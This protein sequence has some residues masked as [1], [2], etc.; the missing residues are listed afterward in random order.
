M[1]NLCGNMA[2]L[3]ERRRKTKWSVEMYETSWIWAWPPLMHTMT[4]F[5]F[6][7]FT[8]SI[9]W[10]LYLTLTAPSPHYQ[11]NVDTRKP[12]S[13]ALR[14]WFVLRI[15]KPN[16]NET[17]YT[18]E[19][20]AH[21]EPLAFHFQRK[22]DHSFEYC[23]CAR[24][25]AFIYMYIDSLAACDFHFLFTAVDFSFSLFGVFFALSVSLQCSSLL[26]TFMR[27]A[28]WFSLVNRFICTLASTRA[29]PNVFVCVCLFVLR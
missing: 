26:L 27:I 5:F 22:F 18:T 16:E 28:K 14:M 15:P 29:C 11:P 24:A 21:I 2:K 8:G 4:M 7:F 25:C 17:S 12:I 9:A 1:E 6:W 10:I 3:W 19:K 20:K 13:I 23:V